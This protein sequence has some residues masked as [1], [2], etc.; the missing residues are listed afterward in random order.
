MITRKELEQFVEKLER[1]LGTRNLRMTI[2]D[3]PRICNWF[4]IATILL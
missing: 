2:N 3:S 4:T 1:M